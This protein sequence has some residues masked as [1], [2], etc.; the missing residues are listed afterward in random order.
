MR[1]QIGLAILWFGWPLRAAEQPS[2]KSGEAL[3]S[4]PVRKILSNTCVRCHNADQKKGGLDL[5]RRAP[6]LEGGKSGA[7]IVPGNFEESL[8]FEKLEAGETPPKSK[9]SAPEVAAVRDWI[10]AG[11]P[12]PGEPVTPPRAGPDWRSL[13]PIRRP[14]VPVVKRSGD[15]RI[16]TP[17]D[18][19]VLAKLQEKGLSQAPEADRATLI[20]RLSFD[21]I[22]LPPLP[23][24]VAAF[25][26]DP[27]PQAYEGLV[28]RLLGSHHYGERWGRH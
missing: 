9:L 14:E 13:R 6:E 3:F 24:D 25:V 12:Y 23:G 18:A 17:I 20:R 28:D 2:S 11:A 21:L 22:G 16:R 26:N 1:W 7:A 10:A 15:S 27:D 4:G 8:A 19:F 5:T